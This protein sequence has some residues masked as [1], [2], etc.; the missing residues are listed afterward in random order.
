M[1]NI[2][3]LRIDYT[4]M[5]VQYIIY[6]LVHINHMPK[7]VHNVHLHHPSSIN[8]WWLSAYHNCATKLTQNHWIFISFCITAR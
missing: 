5:D 7:D 3:V 6:M 2:I 1:Y 8:C 4:L